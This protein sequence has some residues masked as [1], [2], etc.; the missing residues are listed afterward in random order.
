MGGHLAGLRSDLWHSCVWLVV[1]AAVFIPLEKLFA[2]RRQKVLR[3]AAGVD[4]AYY[5]LSGLA[6]KLLLIAPLTIV[7]AIVHRI[8]PSGFYAS[9]AALPLWLR[10]SAG[11]VV[12]EVGAYWAHRASHEIPLLWRF[13]AI[14]HSAEEIDWLVSS[15][16]HP[17]DMAFTRLCGMAPMYLLGLAQPL[18]NRLDLVPIIIT[19][20]GQFWGYFIHANIKWRYGWLEILVS[21]PAFHH[22][23][24]TNDSASVINKNYAAMLPWVDKC[25]GTFYLPG[26]QWPEKYGTDEPMPESLARQLWQPL[27]GRDE[28]RPATVLNG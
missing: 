7:A 15:K 14:H 19:I 10:L 11:M 5:F 20:V 22:W 21:T 8:E 2:V 9:V 27:T 23:H 17:I 18:A 13:H 25:F 4:L 3:R 6:P 16:A 28:E 24:H 26:R 12:G 1:M